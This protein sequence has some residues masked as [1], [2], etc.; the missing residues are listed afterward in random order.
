MKK[1]M[2][3][4]L[5]F[6]MIVVICSSA[7]PA[8]FAREDAGEAVAVNDAAAF[9][10][11]DQTGNYYLTADITLSATY[12]GTFAGTLDG[13]GHTVTVSAPVFE[14]VKGTVKDLVIKGKVEDTSA[15]LLAALAVNAVPGA[16]FEKIVNNASVIGDANNTKRAAGI[17]ALI[18]KGD[19]TVTV[20]GCKNT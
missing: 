8:V 13:K 17:I 9:A 19:G 1:N 7:A 6:L 10:A 11:M 16:V 15:E 20:S 3:V 5:S 12:N 4:L 18:T 14:N 2:A